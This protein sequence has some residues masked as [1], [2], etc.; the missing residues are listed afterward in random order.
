MLGLE[1]PH[2]NVNGDPTASRA[3]VEWSRALTRSRVSLLHAVGRTARSLGLD[4]SGLSD[5]M[6]RE[7]KLTSK[8]HKTTALIF[9]LI[10]F[11]VIFLCLR[12]TLLVTF[13]G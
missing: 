4:P 9:D 7:A 6:T 5:L 2:K 12:F 1:R 8:H 10:L 3:H 13:L 11:Q